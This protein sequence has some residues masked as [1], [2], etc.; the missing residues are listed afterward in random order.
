MIIL[1]AQRRWLYQAEPVG[2]SVEVHR[3]C[4]FP[5]SWRKPPDTDCRSHFQVY[6]LSVVVFTPPTPEWSISILRSFLNEIKEVKVIRF[7]RCSYTKDCAPVAQCP[8]LCLCSYFLVSFFL[9]K[10]FWFILS[11]N[12]TTEHTAA[13]TGELCWAVYKIGVGI[14]AWGRMITNPSEE[15]NVFEGQDSY[16][17]KW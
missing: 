7:R 3:L 8:S 12:G 9:W 4:T 16:N 13:N 15:L 10:H 2:D 17:I 11:E 5:S 1:A 14:L 6:V